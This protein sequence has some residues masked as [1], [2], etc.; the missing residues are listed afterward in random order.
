MKVIVTEKPSVART[1]AKVLAAD[2]REDGY[3]LND[4]WYVTWCRG[5]LVRLCEP[6]EMNPAYA[7]WK[8]EDLPILPESFRY[9]LIDDQSLK[10]QFGIIKNF[11]HGM[12]VTDIYYAGD[13]GREGLY[14]QM[15]VRQQS[16]VR[17][18]IREHV[19]WI[20]SQTPEEIRRGIREAKGLEAYEG[21]AQAGYMRAIEDYV[22]G[23]N[24][25][26]TTTLRYGAMVAAAMG[27]K[28]AT[29]S[30]GR[31]MSCV[32]GMVVRRSREIEKFRKTYYYGLSLPVKGKAA[33]WRAV[34]NSHYV[35]AAGM[36]KDSGFLDKREAQ[37]LLQALKGKD[38]IVEHHEEKSQKKYPPLLFNLTELQAECSRRFHASPQDTLAAAQELYEKQL[39]SYPRTDARALSSAVYSHIRENVTGLLG[40]YPEEAKTA[41]GRG[42]RT[43]RA[44]V[45]DDAKVT[46]HY[47]LIPTGK[48]AGKLIGLQ[49]G[50]YD[51]ICRRFLA[52]FY[53][54]AEYASAQTVIV[55][56]NEP[57]I[58]SQKSRKSAGFE[59][60]WDSGKKV[61]DLVSFEVGE[62]I[63]M[64]ELRIEKKETK[65]PK[66]YTTGTLVLAMENAGQFIEEEELR[67]KIKGSG[68]GT[69]A[70][71][72]ATL[73]K[74]ETI[75][76]LSVEKKTQVVSA[77]R[78]GMMVYEVLASTAPDV[79]SP[80]MTANWEDG[81]QRITEGKLA[82]DDYR[83][84]LYAYVR[85]EVEYIKSGGDG[86]AGKIAPLA[87]EGAVL[88]AS[89]VLQIPC[90]YCG[91]R[92]QMLPNGSYQCE[93]KDL[94]I[95]K[96]GGRYL[97]E[98]EVV[99]LFTDKKIGPFPFQS[100]KG[101]D[102]RAS[103]VLNPPGSKYAISFAFDDSGEPTDIPC[104]KCGKQLDRKMFSLQCSDCGFVISHTYGEKKLSDL[105]MEKLLYRGKTD[106]I[107]GMKS[108][109]G[110][111][112]SCVLTWDG[113]KV[114]FT[115]FS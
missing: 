59:S 34:P 25:S 55:C 52:I 101:K 58:L 82:V 103:V 9:T 57:F 71:R 26:R 89:G 80:R 24:L 92:I 73:E 98:E 18:G 13:P 76:Y 72:A 8:L 12:D 5:H 107:R 43:T 10:K 112:Y 77:T 93:G 54:P 113:E 56:E 37:K 90:P 60:L 62:R 97:T 81:L 39:I 21:L 99:Q 105:Q 44:G 23:I 91:R 68:V 22:T 30:V 88:R 29:I 63:Q 79:L 41:L 38:G 19:V 106:R 3:F 86:L 78:L 108:K 40:I 64:D 74:L 96:V 14:I 83:E 75:G 111:K 2:K 102:F 48:T 11:Y 17:K 67:E 7:H 53:P 100:K 28:H 104:P 95:G 87:A 51:L 42:L 65:P 94:F 66:P 50:V 109:S 110:K 70:T 115:D 46:D 84:K 27:R 1:F 20:E 45:V 47:A 16:G 49:A 31:V 61:E 69:S 36:Y 35:G 114:Q 4:E 32:L 85:K 6:Q 15:L 33:K